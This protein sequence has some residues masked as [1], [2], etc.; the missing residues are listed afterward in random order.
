M[1]VFKCTSLG[2]CG[3]KVIIKWVWFEVNIINIYIY[4]VA[5]AI[6]IFD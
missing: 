6:N 3:L 2:G 5:V 1:N 4:Y